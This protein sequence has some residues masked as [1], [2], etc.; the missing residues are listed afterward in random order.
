M[1][2]KAFIYQ[3]ALGKDY[4]ETRHINKYSGGVGG[5]VDE[6]EHGGDPIVHAMNRE[7]KKELIMNEY[8]ILPLRNTVLFPGQIIPI[9]IGRE[10]SL[11]LENS[12][13]Q[14]EI[15]SMMSPPPTDTT[16]QQ[17]GQQGTVTVVNHSNTQ[18]ISTASSTS[19]QA[20]VGQTQQ[21]IPI[22]NRHG[23]A[24]ASI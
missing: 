3:R 7:L 13:M 14:S 10:M 1:L 18:N 21:S 15:M 11:K 4:Q 8:P 24:P 9:Y 20:N 5:H 19:K 23:A 6:E 12:A 17:A 22:S 16:L 2:K